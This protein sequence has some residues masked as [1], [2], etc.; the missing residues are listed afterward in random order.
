MKELKLENIIK[1]FRLLEFGGITYGYHDGFQY[2]HVP[3][4]DLYIEITP[5]SKT[6]L[7]KHKDIFMPKPKIVN[8]GYASKKKQYFLKS[9]FKRFNKL[10]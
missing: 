4:G 10:I 2:A 5:E 8:K 7:E 3:N 6:F 9:G 1:E